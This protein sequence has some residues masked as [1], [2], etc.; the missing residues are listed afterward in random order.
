MHRAAGPIPR[1]LRPVLAVALGLALLV[2]GCARPAGPAAREAAPA[3]EAEPAASLF[4][5]TVIDDAGRQVTL[6]QAPERIVSLAP[7]NTEVLFALGLGAKVV[8]V[9]D[10]SDYP[11]DGVRDLPRVGGYT[12]PNVEA[13]VALRPDLVLTIAGR[14]SEELAGNLAALGIPVIIVQPQTF[15]DVF[16]KIEFIAR[17]AGAPEAAEELVGRLRQRVEAVR[18]AVAAVPVERRLKVFYEVW[19]DPTGIWTV[20]PGGFIHDVIEVAGGV[21]LFA[22]A[23]APWPKVSPEAVVERNPDAVVTTF[24]DTETQLKTGQRPGWEKLAAVEAGR[25][26][27]IDQNI[28]VRPGPRLVEGL[29]QIARF[30]YP[31]VFR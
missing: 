2:A 5:L 28:I 18:R 19:Y 10:F 23:Q 25:I 16:D 30:L 31:D 24:P 11:P 13:I 15:A 20:G 1:R 7:S 12:T 26:L 8:G 14:K 9:D 27:V 6:E 17:L 21:N 22:D 29:E 3:A 4:P